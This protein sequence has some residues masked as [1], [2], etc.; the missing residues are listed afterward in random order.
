M[1]TAIPKTGPAGIS[2]GMVPQPQ[3]RK[4][5]L[6]ADDSAEIRESLGKLLRG[7]GYDVVFAAHGGHVLDRALNEPVDLLLLDLNMPQMDGWD[8]LD[9]LATMKPSLPII[10]ITAQPNQKDWVTSAGAHALMEKPLD[11]PLL[12]QTIED[13]LREPPVAATK[14]SPGVFRRERF[15]YGWP[16]RSQPGPELGIRRSGINE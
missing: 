3:S 2:A 15:R 10:I 4:R 6:L 1:T 11:L 13:F 7:A 9:H 16:R 8:A 14:P 12:L 5:L